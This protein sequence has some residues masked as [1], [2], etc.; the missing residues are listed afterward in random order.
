MVADKSLNMDITKIGALTSIFPI[1]YG[2]SK[3]ASGVLGARTPAHLLL[4]GG[5]MATALVNIFFGF[6]TS[7]AWFSV[8]W[9]MNGLLQVNALTPCAGL[10]CMQRHGRCLRIV[11]CTLFL[12]RFGLPCWLPLSCSGC[13]GS[14]RLIVHSA[15]AGV[16]K[17]VLG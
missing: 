9:A 12:F 6:G 15:F 10:G 17:P 2:F 3:F 5:L 13:F 1:F 16:V 8:F 11:P 4:G 14:V 7:L